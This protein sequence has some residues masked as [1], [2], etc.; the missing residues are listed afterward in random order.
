MSVIN[1]GGEWP[2]LA[3]KT[4]AGDGMLMLHAARASVVL[5]KT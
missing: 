4:T 3:V 1:G 2:Q 5:E